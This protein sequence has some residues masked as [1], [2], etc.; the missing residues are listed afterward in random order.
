MHSKTL[1][2]A[3]GLFMLAGFISLVI[4]ALNVS[5]LNLS[6]SKESYTIYA[7]F[8][9]I[10]GLTNRSKVTVAGVA[11]GRVTGISLD[12][13]E[14]SGIVEMAIDAEYDRFTTDTTAAIL[15]AGLLGEK[16]IGL[17]SGADDTYLENGDMIED[18]QSALV[19]E[20]LI[21]QFLFNKVNE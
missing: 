11:V 9:N 3:V 16:Y 14:F 21:G 6:Q 12:K 10:G 2:V 1:E 5:G 19:L 20:E 7:S 8:E 17:V 15:T 4:L 18:T 13:D